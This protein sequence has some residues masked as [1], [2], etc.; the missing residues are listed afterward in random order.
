MAIIYTY[1][2]INQV[3]GEDLLLISDTNL[4]KRPTRSVTVD[5]LAAYIGTVVGVV[6]NLQSVL[7]VGN[8]YVSPDGYGTFTLNDIT[9][10]DGQIKYVNTDEGWGY[11][12]SAEEGFNITNGSGTNLMS[13]YSS[14]LSIRNGAHVMNIGTNALTATRNVYFPDAS[15]T[16]ALTS[17]IPSPGPSGS[18]TT[19][20]TARWTSASALGIGTLYD[21]GTNV[22]I[23]TTTPTQKLE[24]NGTM[25]LS[26]LPNNNGRLC[27]GSVSTNL[28]SNAASGHLYISTNG[29]TRMTILNNGN[30]GIG[31]TSPS[32]KLD[33]EG[34]VRVGVNNG[35]YINNQNVGIKR[36]SND[37]V[38]GGFGNVIIRS[39]STTVVNQAERMRITSAGN[40]GI[41]TS[42]PAYILDVVSPGTAT[43]RLKSAGTGAISLRYEN[44]GGFK[45]AAVVDNNGLYRLDATNI[46]LNPTNNVGIGTTSPSEK[47]HI[48]GNIKLLDKLSFTEHSTNDYLSAESYALVVSGDDSINF[49]VGGTSSFNVYTT[50]IRP[51]STNTVDLGHTSFGW[52]TVRS[53]GNITTSAGAVGIGTQY[54]TSALDV[55]SNS[56]GN[57]ID[58]RSNSANAYSQIRFY[59]NDHTSN[60]G[61]IINYH[62]SGSPD[63]AFRL[64]SGAG[65]VERMRI[66]SVGNVGIGTTSP[67]QKLHIE[68]SDPR[69]RIVDTDGTN[70]ESEVF[71]QGGALKLQARNG[72]NFGNISFQGDNGTTESEYARF[73]SVGNF[74]I[75]TN[76][77]SAKLEV[78]GGGR[79]EVMTVKG[80]N[81]SYWLYDRDLNNRGQE[82]F[83][84]SR[85]VGNLSFYDRTYNGGYE[86]LEFL[87]FSHGTSGSSVLS[88]KSK[89]TIDFLINQSNVARI[90]SSGNV[91]IGTTNPLS[92]LN[93]NGSIKIEGENQLY[94]GS[95]GSVP[96]WEIKASGSDLVINDTGSNVGSVL[97][98]NDEGIVL[99]R[100]TTTEINA[101]SLPNTGLTVYNTTLNTL[102]FYNGSSWQ[103]V[104]HTS[105]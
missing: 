90:N 104:S 28:F 39:S 18:G 36:T 99:P 58:L 87:K 91:G 72:T 10:N 59:N 81:S 23:G 95:S 7:T 31:N 53:V 79:F 54:P 2:E 48:A 19:N 14:G 105:M 50:Q 27:L 34:N 52:K 32:E 96:L 97:F 103:K 67:S 94:F 57:G 3:E 98:N 44:G 80:S 92:K 49:R 21:N 77:P 8:T 101:I 93:V 37:L 51:Q 84:I 65:T 75:G 16:I 5:D 83:R 29:S 85:N 1:P 46:S 69:I 73:N 60:T 30:V 17:D 66:T 6:Q 64:L 71:T 4:Y 13:I 62:N 61:S 68:A 74:G 78:A 42:S 33:V 86:E 11:L 41:G 25:L 89:S 43:A 76:S 38:L 56:S 45:S 82:S 63:F 55:I 20:Y 22:G 35:F 26:T 9:N 24:V 40:I 100:L 88:L 70:W 12:I 102:C 15:G 47:L